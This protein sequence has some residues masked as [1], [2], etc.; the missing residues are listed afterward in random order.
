MR[1]LGLALVLLVAA[2]GPKEA[3]KPPPEQLELT[4]IAFSALAGWGDDDQAEALPALRRSCGRLLRQ[5]DERPVG[6]DAV[7]GTVADWRAPCGAVEQ[8]SGVDARAMRALL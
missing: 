1:R 4:P 8:A 7:A 6:P 2:C 3:P 5:S